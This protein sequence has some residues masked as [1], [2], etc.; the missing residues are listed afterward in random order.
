[1]QVRTLKC[2]NNKHT[3]REPR[4]RETS[5]ITHVRLAFTHK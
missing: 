3:P 1:M 5:F 2:L 4:A